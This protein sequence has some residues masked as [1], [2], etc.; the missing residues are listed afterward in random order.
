ME[1][2][3]ALYTNPTKDITKEAM[4]EL[5]KLEAEILKMN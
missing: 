4:Q 2:T 5:L 1:E 3:Q